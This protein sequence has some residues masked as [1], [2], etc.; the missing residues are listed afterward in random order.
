MRHK[1]KRH[2][3]QINE[4]LAEKFFDQRRGMRDRS[5]GEAERQRNGRSERVYNLG[6]YPSAQQVG[7]DSDETSRE[8]PTHTSREKR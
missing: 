3:P 1:H 6:C 5:C 4:L 7:D 8:L 2:R